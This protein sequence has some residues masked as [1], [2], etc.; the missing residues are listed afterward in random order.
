MQKENDNVEDRGGNH[1]LFEHFMHSWV[2]YE[3][4]QNLF[5]YVLTPKIRT[6]LKNW[7]PQLHELFSHFEERQRNPEK[8]PTKMIEVLFEN[9]EHCSYFEK[10]P[11]GK[12]TKFET[13]SNAA[14]PL[15][16]LTWL[17]QLQEYFFN[18]PE[19]KESRDW[20]DYG[21]YCNVPSKY[22]VP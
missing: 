3:I 12:R 10:L 14:I 8:K 7:L 9:P 6:D 13:M 5:K 22:A 15:V 18:Q 2:G 21:Q 19:M 17:R 16:I 1:E 11:F 4:V 20:S